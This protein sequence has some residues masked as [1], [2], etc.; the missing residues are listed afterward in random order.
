[1][2]IRKDDRRR[3]AVE[4]QEVR[5]KRTPQE[6]LKLLDDRFGE[7]KGATKE[8]ASLKAAIEE[9]EKAKQDEQ[10]KKEKKGKKE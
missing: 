6:Q 7:G 2:S 5:A 3:R 8:R 10:E 9:V 1:M 4:R